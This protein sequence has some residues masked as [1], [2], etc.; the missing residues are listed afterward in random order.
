M[1]SMLTW[2]TRPSVC[3]ESASL[4]EPVSS[5]PSL[6]LQTY[7]R[8]ATEG[9]VRLAFAASPHTCPAAQ[10]EK[11]QK[12]EGRQQEWDRTAHHGCNDVRVHAESPL[13][14]YAVYLLF[15]CDR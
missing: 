10:R 15:I 6:P 3:N 1:P 9:T 4:Y 11:C 12:C 5:G 8:F 13:F 7:T 14:T 2:L